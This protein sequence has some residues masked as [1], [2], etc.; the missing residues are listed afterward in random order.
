MDLHRNGDTSSDWVRLDGTSTTDPEGDEVKFE[1]WSDR[2]GL[3]A[4][5]STPDSEIQWKGELSKGTHTITMNAGDTRGEHAGMWSRTEQQIVVLNSP[6][7]ALIAAPLDGLYTDSSELVLL[8]ATGSGDWDLYCSD[9]PDNGSGL[10]CNPR[11]L[12]SPDLVSVL[13]ESDQLE[14]PLGSDWRLETRLPAGEHI[15]TL[16]LNDGSV[17]VSDQIAVSVEESA[18]VLVLDSPVPDIEVYSNLP[19]LFDFRG[20][21]DADGDQFTVTVLSDITGVILE[22]R[23]IEYWYNDYMP[24]GTHTLTFILT[25]SDG[26]QRTHT[27][28]ITVLETGPVA[29][30]SGLLDGQYVPPGH[31]IALS[32]SDSFDYDEDIVLYQWSLPSGVVLSDRQNVTLS[33]PPG[34][35][36]VNLMVQDS[37]GAESYASINITIGSSAPVL[38]DIAVSVPEIEIDVPTDVTTTVRLEDPDGTTD[39]VRGE[40]TSD[41]ISEVLYFRDDG[42]GGDQIAGDGN[43]T[44]RSNWL[45][46]GGS[47]VK[48]EVWAIDG[49]LVSPGIVQ[50]V[51][52]VQPDEGG[53]VSWLASSGLPFLII[54]VLLLSLAGATYQRRRKQEIAK[55]LAEIERWSSFVPTEIDLEFDEEPSPPPPQDPKE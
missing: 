39:T 55:D 54:S 36:R 21:F 40:M 26:L 45:A 50:T 5:G 8:D 11:P 28:A 35:V 30:I 1:F 25:D 29:V 49:D 41:G 12:S 38:L 43:W 2:D 42:Q 48:I 23:T 46:S 20:S 18:P 53:L 47:W 37:R 22:N 51:P 33:F 14:E 10:L 3:L 6:P 19:I 24:A 13:W 31:K 4:S 16:T 15:I 27:Q 17:S 7:S 44:H 32:A 52:I 9:L 34:P